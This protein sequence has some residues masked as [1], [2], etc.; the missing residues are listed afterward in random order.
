MRKT[1]SKSA[2]IHPG[3]WVGVARQCR[4]TALSDIGFTEDQIT[5][6][7]AGEFVAVRQDKGETWL[8]WDINGSDVEIRVPTSTLRAFSDFELLPKPLDR[9]AE[10][11]ALF[12][13]EPVTIDNLSTWMDAI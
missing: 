2:R 1:L 10:S 6:I 4:N 13:T 5:R 11:V 12:A 7:K 8:V 9:T 3:A